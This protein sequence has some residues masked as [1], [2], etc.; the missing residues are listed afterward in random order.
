MTIMSEEH[1]L[2]PRGPGRPAKY[3]WNEWF[4]HGQTIR[5]TRGQHYDI[6]TEN[7]RIQVNKA[8]RRHSGR[9]STE[10]VGHGQGLMFTFYLEDDLDLPDRN[11]S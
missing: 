11:V 1:A 8:A 5:V 6:S 3:P 7:F 10:I 2:P 9:V 4:K